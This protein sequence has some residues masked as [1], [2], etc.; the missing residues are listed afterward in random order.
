MTFEV[1]ANAERTAILTEVPLTNAIRVE[2]YEGYCLR[3]HSTP[4]T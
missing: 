2:S 1:V 3:E 4:A